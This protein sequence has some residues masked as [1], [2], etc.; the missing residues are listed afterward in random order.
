MTTELKSPFCDVKQNYALAPSAGDIV[1]GRVIHGVRKI[2]ATD[3][4]FVMLQ[5]GGP[6][7]TWSLERKH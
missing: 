4:Y 7:L 3:E 1:D 6:W 2:V 5:H